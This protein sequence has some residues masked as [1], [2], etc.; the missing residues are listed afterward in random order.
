M[1]V[2]YTFLV[3]R[4]MHRKIFI[5]HN[6]ISKTSTFCMKKKIISNSSESDLTM[7][8]WWKTEKSM[9]C[10]RKSFKLKMWLRST[11]QDIFL[12]LPLVE[13]VWYDV[14]AGEMRGK[15]Y[16]KP[17][18][19]ISLWENVGGKKIHIKRKNFN[20]NFKIRTYSLLLIFLVSLIFV[21]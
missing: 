10:L 20:I 3:S 19:K 13:V 16:K 11:C 6:S 21:I 8:R 14:M 18:K 12:A 15:I 9:K 2:K 4:L 17:K 5:S 1:H 7:M